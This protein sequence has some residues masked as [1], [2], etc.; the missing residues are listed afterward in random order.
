MS[1]QTLITSLG[2]SQD[3]A[4]EALEVL[5]QVKE[6]LSSDTI[7]ME[8]FSALYMRFEEIRPFVPAMEKIRPLM[9][10][11]RNSPEVCIVSTQC[12]EYDDDNCIDFGRFEGL[13][14]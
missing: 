9:K 13:L 6:V 3:S 5:A 12:D 11:L 1:N 8:E 10:G 7:D 4:D 2:I 14:Q